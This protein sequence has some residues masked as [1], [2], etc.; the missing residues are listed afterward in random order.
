MRIYL[1]YHAREGMSIETHFFSVFSQS[2][3]CEI[4]QN[5]IDFVL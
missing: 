2:D 3:S 4:M 1:L 5:D